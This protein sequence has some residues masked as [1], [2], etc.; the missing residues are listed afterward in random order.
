MT[1][2]SGN[3]EQIEVFGRV[4]KNIPPCGETGKINRS[5][6][7][8]AWRSRSRSLQTDAAENE[9]NSHTN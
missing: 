9:L 2:R 4:S 7:N 6:D 8:P 1:E 3:A 5:P